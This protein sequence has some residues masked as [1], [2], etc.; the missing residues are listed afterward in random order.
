M[1]VPKC[2]RVRRAR[3]RSAASAQWQR[4]V[5]AEASPRFDVLGDGWRWNVRNVHELGGRG[6]RHLGRPNL[7]AAN[8]PVPPSGAHLDDA[9]LNL[10]A[11]GLAQ[12]RHAETRAQHSHASGSRLNDE[13]RVTWTRRHLADDASAIHD[14]QQSL[15]RFGAD[16]DGGLGFDVDGQPRKR[17]VRG[18]RAR[19]DA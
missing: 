18:G 4:V 2:L 13:R 8:A 11:G 12:T 1:F 16:H 17:E 5:P 7:A 3:A 6:C 9:L 15:R 10:H 19:G 14:D